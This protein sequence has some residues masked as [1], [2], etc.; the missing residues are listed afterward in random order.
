MPQ[1]S[2][3][4]R[5]NIRRERIADDTYDRQVTISVSDY[6]TISASDYQGNG[7]LFKRAYS[8]AINRIYDA[9]VIVN[10]SVP[11]GDYYFPGVADVNR[12]H[13]LQAPQFGQ[14]LITG[15]SRVGTRPSAGTL[16]SQTKSQNYTSLATYHPT[17]FHF[18][19]N[20]FYINGS[21]N[22][23]GGFYAASGFTNIGF[24]GSWNGSPGT[25]TNDSVMRRGLR[26]NFKLDY[27]SIFGFDGNTYE[28]QG[29]LAEGGNIS[30]YDITICNCNRGLVAS[31]NGS[32]VTDYSS[33]DIIAQHK[34]EGLIAYGNSFIGLGDGVQIRTSQSVGSYGAYAYESSA[35]RIRNA[36][37]SGGAGNY[38]YPDGSTI[39]TSTSY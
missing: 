29:I 19:Y 17:R 27:C 32:F 6:G 8:D 24:F 4:F 5:N 35:I 11:A 7:D 31:G 23:G 28:S 12:Y 39:H 33:T 3:Y 15:A 9:N 30:G 18:N 20:G 37:V 38:A 14:I 21:P 10:I 1:Y 13:T 26:G 16:A 2:S 34:A 36:T 22:G 25:L